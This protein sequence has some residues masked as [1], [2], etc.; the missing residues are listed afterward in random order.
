M[1]WWWF[2]SY[3][4]VHALQVSQ[5]TSHPTGLW[6]AGLGPILFVLYHADLISLIESHGLSPHLYTSDAHCTRLQLV[7][8]ICHGYAIIACAADVATW[9][10]SNR[11]PLHPDKTG[12]TGTTVW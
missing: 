6:H 9:M 10:L 4:S 3:L 7:F 12:P 8:A 1:W 2:Q 5:V 11:L